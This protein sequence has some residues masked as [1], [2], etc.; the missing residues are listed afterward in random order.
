MFD[1]NDDAK[2]GYRRVEVLTGPGRRRHWSDEEKARILAEA[3]V[4]G[5]SVSAVARRWQVCPQ[6]VFGWRRQARLE[7]GGLSRARGCA[8]MALVPIV[9]GVAPAPTRTAAPASAMIEVRLEGA[10]V[11]VM[12]GTDAALLT[13]VLCAVRASASAA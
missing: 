5:A 2:A 6:Q 4:A 9:S 13:T 3:G 11:R 12:S 1:V 8:E 7:G 10:V